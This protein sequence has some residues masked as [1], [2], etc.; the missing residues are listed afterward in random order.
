MFSKYLYNILYFQFKISKF[1]KQKNFCL[2]FPADR[3]EVIDCKCKNI[4]LT[5]VVEVIPS[6]QC[7]LKTRN[8]L[9]DDNEEFIKKY[10]QVKEYYKERSS[11]IKFHCF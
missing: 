9:I 1:I 11:V 10:S 8:Q 5:N 3:T 6:F 2:D 7:P 4:H